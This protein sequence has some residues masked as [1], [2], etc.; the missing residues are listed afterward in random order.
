MIKV[1]HLS[2]CFGS[3]P[4]VE[5]LSF[6]VPGNGVYG[7]L[8]PN[9]AGKT[10]TMNILTGYLS[11]TEGTVEIA[12][13]DILTQPKQ[14]KA[15]VGYLPEHPPLYVDMTAEEY[16]LFAAELKGIRPRAARAAAVEKAV[17]RAGL[18][19]VRQRLIRNLSKGYCQRV[20]IAAVLLGEP[21]IVILDEPT[22]GLDP[23]QMIEMR[24]M[25]RDL[26][27]THAVI[28]SSHILSEVQSVCDH[29][30]IISE[31]KLV[32]QG[33]PGELAA[34]LA[35]GGKLH[36]TAQGKRDKILSAAG[37]I[38]GLSSVCVVEEKENE[39]SF[40]AQTPAGKDLR[41]AVSA[42]LGA[43][44]CPVLAFSSE[45]VSLEDV[46][47]QLTEQKERKAE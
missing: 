41:A 36:V 18:Q 21:K 3:N 23:A 20:G 37:K 39:V 7:L 26:G 9:G 1:S 30:L 34:K 45:A 10:T 47:L 43:A 19:S 4:A 32:A 16:L 15:C 2:K 38:R 17:A 29:V 33:T 46:F 24:S 14:A 12:G 28:L 13:F 8:G 35:S 42:A 6:S 11:A 27:K 5:D 44:G 25:I 22:V 31:G 40:T